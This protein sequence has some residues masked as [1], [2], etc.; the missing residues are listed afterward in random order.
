MK[1]VTVALLLFCSGIKSDFAHLPELPM[2]KL[3]LPAAPPLLRHVEVPELHAMIRA[4][5]KKHNVPA[6]F[7]K[8][9]VAAES[10]FD[11]C[12]VSPVGALGPMQLM[13]ATA[14]E[15]GADA[16][17][18][19]QNIDAGTHYLRVLLNRYSRYRNGMTRA[20][21]AYNA[22]PGVVDRYHGVPPYRET[23]GYV[24]RVLGYF[25][26]FQKERG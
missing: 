5:A 14:L 18:P 6:A 2:V 20:I 17:I 19:E 15:Y 1:F 11:S 23:R 24:V 7:V 4:A 22:G 16:T 9:I 12:A 10:N 8:S 13:Q 25:K 26:H 21:A 3:P